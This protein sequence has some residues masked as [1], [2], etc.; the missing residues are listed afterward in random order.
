MLSLIRMSLRRLRTERAPSVALGLLVLVSAFA[1]TAGGRLL[2]TSSDA[3][4]RGEVAAAPAGTADLELVEEGRE[5]AGAADDPM[6]PVEVRGRKHEARIPAGLRSVIA[7]RHYIVDSPF[8]TVLSD[9]PENSTVALRIQQG[10]DARI[11]YTAGEAPT[12]EVRRQTFPETG[13]ASILVLQGALAAPSALALQVEVGDI[14]VVEPD[15][16][17]PLALGGLTPLAVE[18]VGLFEAGNVADAY[19]SGDTTALLPFIRAVATD[20]EYLSARLLISAEAYSELLTATSADQPALRYQWRYLVSGDLLQADA[21]E[22]LVG[23]L[24]RMQGLFPAS[25]TTSPLNGTLQ[26]TGLLRL[27]EKEQARWSS[28]ETLIAVV[29]LGVVAAGLAA[30]ALVAA[31]GLERRGAGLATWRARG[32]TL[33]Q[34]G[35]AA[36]GEAAL[37][38]LPPAAIGALLAVLLVPARGL[39]GVLLGGAVSALVVV[40][41][42][43]GVVRS[44][45]GAKVAGR[46][47]RIVRRPNAR[48]LMV[49]ALVV[50]LAVGGAVLVRQ[51]GVAGASSTGEVGVADPLLAAVPALVGAAAGL[52]VLRLLPIPMR[53]LTAGAGLRRDLVPILG[54]RRTTRE[55]STAPVLIVLL[56]TATIATFSLATLVYLDRSAD[57][58]SWH[59]V[60][61]PY[62]VVSAQGVLPRGAADEP[63]PGSDLTARAYTTSVTSRGTPAFELLA[64]DLETYR[65]IIAGTPLDS[66]LP[67]E[68]LAA[69]SGAALPAIMSPSVARG[70]DG[71]QVGDVFEVALRGRTISVEAVA[72]RDTF[73]TLPVDGRFAVISLPQA[74]AAHPELE[75]P[76]NSLFVSAGPGALAELREAAEGI[77]GGLEVQAR[78]ETGRNLRATP[79]MAAV[80]TMITAG[81]A[82]AAGYTALAVA[83]SVAVAG[84]A[85][86]NEVGHLRTLGLSRRQGIGLVIA[87]H[88]TTIL[89]GFVAGTLL[90][91]WLFALLRPGLGLDALTGSTLTIPVVLGVEHIGLMAAAFL[92]IALI[93]IGLSAALQHA[94]S[95]AIAVRRGIE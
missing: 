82:L 73:P 53:L 2:A 12:A 11:T 1:A 72:V 60:G 67:E 43:A 87:E 44:A 74:Q 89:I 29:A 70:T 18:V 24:R 17:D 63:L 25:A 65:R 56:A 39:T 34:V 68:M 85:R 59:N 57:A 35:V 64:V 84:A 19:W 36:I 88:G 80:V 58:A 5:A 8:F 79:V 40:V 54:L 20:V 69:S 6:A 50:L 15:R 90:G 33:P 51:R 52:L 94:A 28:A 41:A 61:A 49:E 62:R 46:A 76:T 55:G 3:A 9:T 13:T 71:V 95:P 37:I 26:R 81:V 22:Q 86:A 42:T 4:L 16:Y 45:V 7:D 77:S 38:I 21:A 14:L 66:P 31:V 30:I 10:V 23:E 75:I 91:L 93:G 92:G 78:E 32:A 47:M 48:R 27:I 83:A